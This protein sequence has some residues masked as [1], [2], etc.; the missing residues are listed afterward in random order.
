MLSLHISHVISQFLDRKLILRGRTSDIKELCLERV[1][2]QGFFCS[3]LKS[4]AEGAEEIIQVHI[5]L[6]CDLVK[7]DA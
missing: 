1:S 5:W 7:H 4:Q 6:R 2:F 3:Q